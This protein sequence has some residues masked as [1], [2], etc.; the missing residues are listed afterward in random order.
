MSHFPN[1]SYYGQYY[2]NPQWIPAAGG[3][4]PSV[5]YNN[6]VN[7]TVGPDGTHYF[8]QTYSGQFVAPQSP[9]V[10]MKMTIAPPSY[11]E[12][13]KPETEKAS[14]S[15]GTSEL[16]KIEN[17]VKAANDKV[18]DWGDKYSS[19]EDM[20]AT[21]DEDYEGNESDSSSQEEYYR[22]RSS[23]HEDKTSPSPLQ[24]RKF[25]KTSAERSGCTFNDR[26][27]GT[28]GLSGFFLKQLN[29]NSLRP[30]FAANV[31]LSVDEVGRTKE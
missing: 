19:D 6:V 8:H 4:Q 24:K 31:Q 18:Q 20:W 9:T 25:S 21:E 12:A 16:G 1:Q 13:V 3:S 5:V 22:S 17:E 2:F 7:F 27:Y 14:G 11:D 23:L 15:A 30:K 28:K 29:C 26:V 10:D